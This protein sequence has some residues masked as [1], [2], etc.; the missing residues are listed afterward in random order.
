MRFC[1]TFLSQDAVGHSYVAQV[2]QHSSQTDA[3]RGFG[4]K[5]G[6]QKDRVDQVGY[7]YYTLHHTLLDRIIHR[8]VNHI[9]MNYIVNVFK[10]MICS[11]FLIYFTISCIMCSP[12]LS[13]LTAVPLRS[14]L[15]VLSIKGKLSNTPLRKVLHFTHSHK[16]RQCSGEGKVWTHH[17]HLPRRPWY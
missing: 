1:W 13:D 11:A 2:A 5:F 16:Q 10:W 8:G 14:R 4:G 15:W 6:V 9:Y 12:P 17:S 3:S 7:T